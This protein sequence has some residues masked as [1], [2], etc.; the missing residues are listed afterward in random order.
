MCE[1]LYLE[2]DQGVSSEDSTTPAQHGESDET[3]QQ[4]NNSIT[5]RKLVIHI[6][7]PHDQGISIEGSTT[8]VQHG[9][10][11]EMGQQTNNIITV[12]ELVIHI[13]TRPSATDEIF[14]NLAIQA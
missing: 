11:D 8:A 9:E 10:S 13:T 4:T 5:V 7:S 2:H 3:G 1:G 14:S 12:R 6:T